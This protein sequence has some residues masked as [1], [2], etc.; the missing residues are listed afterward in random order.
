[1]LRAVERLAQHLHLQ[2]WQAS[3]RVPGASRVGLEIPSF[4]LQANDGVVLHPHAKERCARVLREYFRYQGTTYRQFQSMIQPSR[5][6]VGGGKRVQT[7]VL[8]LG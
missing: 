5:T 3:E 2:V 1:M 8:Q 6:V 7:D 4:E